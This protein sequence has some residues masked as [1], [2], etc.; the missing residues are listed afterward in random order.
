MGSSAAFSSSYADTGASSHAISFSYGISVELSMIY[1][2]TS[3]SLSSDLSDLISGA[4]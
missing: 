4:V 2:L 1:T 3:F